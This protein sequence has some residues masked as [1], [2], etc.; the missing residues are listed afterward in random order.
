MRRLATAIDSPRPVHVPLSFVLRGNAG[1][2]LR[3]RLA[4]LLAPAVVLIAT[5]AFGQT[6]PASTDAPAASQPAATE[7]KPADAPFLRVVEDKNKSIELQIASR[8]YVREDG[9]G[10]RIAL[11]AVAH[12]GD[13]SF[14]HGVQDLLKNYDV[15]LYESVKPPG[16]SKPGGETTEQRVESTRAA[17]RFAAGLIE[18]YRAQHEAYPDDVETLKKFAAEHDARLGQF[19]SVALVDA[20]NRP[21]NYALNA[22]AAEDADERGY[23]LVSLGADGKAGGEDENVDLDLADEA[24]PDP[25]MLSEDDGL[26]S[27]LADALGLEFQLEALDYGA[28]NWR[29]SDMAMDELNRRLQEKGLDFEMLG[30]TLAGSSLPAKIIQVLLGMMKMLDAFTDGAITDTFKVVMIEMLGD[31][32]LI[33]LSMN[34]LGEGFGEVIINDRNQVAVDDLK[35]IIEKEPA[36][37]SVAVLY[38]A[39]HMGHLEKQLREQVGYVPAP[40]GEQWLT[41][42]KVDLTK[43]AMTPR[44]ISQIRMMIRQAIKRQ[45]SVK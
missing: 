2:W 8:D 22:A 17:M 23:T 38:G 24:P 40:D 11:V 42:M 21:L 6:G 7:Q 10:P 45:M 39:G 34:Q 26:Q 25:T 33:D 43:S 3:S 27:Q 13:K 19:L 44:E 31:P 16:T 18:S 1:R 9:T 41:A 30:G 36:I 35:A 28:A 15:V 12:I 5:R 4:L 32:A 29:C 37:E 20:W 14:Y